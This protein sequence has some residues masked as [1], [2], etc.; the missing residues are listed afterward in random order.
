MEFD[1]EA[2]SQNELKSYDP[3]EQGNLLN[4]R[5][6]DNDGSYLTFA[7]TRKQNA[8]TVFENK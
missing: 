7:I 4:M 5:L 3:S 1:P 6:I 8:I 2:L